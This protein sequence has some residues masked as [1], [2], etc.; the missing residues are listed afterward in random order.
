VRGD[1]LQPERC[2]SMQ[3]CDTVIH[4]VGIIKETKAFRFSKRTSRRRA[5]CSSGQAERASKRYIQM[6]AL[7]TRP[8]AASTYHQTK[9]Q[10]EELVRASG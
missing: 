2:A 10:A 7:G 1:V 6:S 3:G 8:H 9:W 5:T 4:L